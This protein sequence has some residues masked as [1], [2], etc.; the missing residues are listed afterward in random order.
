MSCLQD[1]VLNQKQAEGQADLC[2]AGEEDQSRGRGQTLCWKAVG[3]A[4]GSETG[5]GGEHGTEPNKQV[6]HTFEFPVIFPET[7]SRVKCCQKFEEI[8]SIVFS[9][10]LVES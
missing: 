7:Y 5:G 6:T 10:F 4:S 9:C 2:D 1:S 3:W 8:D